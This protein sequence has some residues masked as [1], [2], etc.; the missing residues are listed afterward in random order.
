MNSI[1][2]NYNIFNNAIK[3]NIKQYCCPSKEDYQSVFTN[4]VL[5]HIN[6]LLKDVKYY[7]SKHDYYC[8]CYLNVNTRHRLLPCYECYFCGIDNCKESH[9]EVNEEFDSVEVSL[10]DILKCIDDNE[11]GYTRE[12]YFNGYTY[13]MDFTSVINKCYYWPLENII[14]FTSSRNGRGELFLKRLELMSAIEMF[15]R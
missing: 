6:M 15:K 2:S 1:L 13:G 3:W 14:Y 12:C 7:C 4:E 9:A 11:G 5:P 10:Y 8:D